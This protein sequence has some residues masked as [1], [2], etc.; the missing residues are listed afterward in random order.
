MCWS[1]DT[2]F[3]FNDAE[4]GREISFWRLWDLGSTS[5][6]GK[7]L[8]VAKFLGN[9]SYDFFG[10]Y[11]T[12]WVAVLCFLENPRVWGT[13]VIRFGPGKLLSVFLWF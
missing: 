13:I 4:E 6:W 9:V 12:S 2:T 1:D 5:I 11:V 3:S 10:G 8:K 7:V